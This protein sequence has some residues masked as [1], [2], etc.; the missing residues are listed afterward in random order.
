M[1]FQ[2]II[3][4]LITCVVIIAMLSITA[5]AAPYYENELID[6]P[7]NN[8]WTTVYELDR[9]S[10]YSYVNARCRTAFPNTGD[11]NMSGVRV[12]VMTYSNGDNGA[13]TPVMRDYTSYCTIPDNGIV[14]KI[15]I[16][17]GYLNLPA[18]YLQFKS[19]TSAAGKALITCSW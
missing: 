9:R 3:S 5:F 17:D 16:M 18:V 12:R 4:R 8:I 11:D 14:K 13:I 19:V 15:Y 7:A 1:K 10:G 6:L 2:R